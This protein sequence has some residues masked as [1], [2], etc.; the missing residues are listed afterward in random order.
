MFGIT[1]ERMY[2]IKGEEDDPKDLCLHG[3]VEVIIG[4]ETFSYNAT[5]SATALYLLKTL[6]EDHLIGEEIQMLPCCGHFIIPAANLDTV[7]ISGCSNGID[8]SVIHENDY[9]RLIT[10]SGQE[11]SIPIEDYISAVF[12]FSDIVKAF[13][14]LCSPKEVGDD[15]FERSGYIAFWNEWNRRRNQ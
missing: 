11:V 1:V 4:A 13:Y 9:V 5:V 2:W 10:E 8:W 7:D 3:D 6:T 15:E 12:H 14:D